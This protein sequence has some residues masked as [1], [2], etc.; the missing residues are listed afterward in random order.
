MSRKNKKNKPRIVLKNAVR[1]DKCGCAFVPESKTQR[2]GEIEYSYFN[3]DY[4]GKAYLVSVTDA[5]LRKDIRKYRTLAE[6]LKGK[7][8][9]EDTLRE[10]AS[11]KEQNLK[12]SA[13][14]RQIYI[15]EG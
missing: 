3:C 7:S 9:S 14:L 13:K 2:E 10:M 6:K 12:R 4:C 8:L 15:L 1:C 11:L 5:D